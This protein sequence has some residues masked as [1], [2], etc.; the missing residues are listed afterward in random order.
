MDSELQEAIDYFRSEPVFQKILNEMVKKYYIYGKFTGTINKSDL[1]NHE[2]LLGFMGIDDVQWQKNSRFKIED[3]LIAYD[4]SKFSKVDLATLITLI[5]N[6]EL[7]TKSEVM[8]KQQVAW[9]KYVT[10]FEKNYPLLFNAVGKKLANKYFLHKIS[11]EI[12]SRVEKVITNFPDKLMRLPVFAYQILND[13]HGLDNNKIIGRMVLDYLKIKFDSDKSDNEIYLM[14]NLVKDDILNFV[15]L[16]NFVSDNMIFKVAAKEHLIWNVPLMQLLKLSEVRPASGKKI[17]IIENSS[18]YAIV[19][20]KI[21]EVP[22]VMTSGQFKFATWYLLSLLPKDI[23]IYYASDLDPAGLIMS[24]N[25]WKLY[26]DRVHFVGMSLELYERYQM[27]GLKLSDN[28]LSKLMNVDVP[29]LMDLKD[30]IL[31]H[32]KAVYQEAEIS[33]I[34]IEIKKNLSDM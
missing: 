18:V 12:L 15:T 17:F 6:K 2:L 34:I 31:K 9:E 11:A 32:Q 1:I 21:P 19:A 22:L 10:D 3:F 29:P 20:E 23:Q 26:G 8:V 5:T 13:P 27:H 16:Q 7:V 33:E 4:K 14:V 24:Q 30:A 28:K 25:I